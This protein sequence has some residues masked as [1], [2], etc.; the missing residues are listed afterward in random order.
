MSK[1]R[2]PDRSDAL[3]WVMTLL[4]VAMIAA[5]RLHA[6]T[7][8][9]HTLLAAASVAVVLQLVSVLRD[10]RRLSGPGA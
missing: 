9:F 6:P 7:A 4:V 1:L 2:R 8:I 5:D 10:V 3:G